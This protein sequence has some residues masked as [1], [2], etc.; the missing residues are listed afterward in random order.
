MSTPPPR[1][2][3]YTRLHAGQPLFDA[4]QSLATCEWLARLAQRACTQRPRRQV[5]SLYVVLTLA[6]GQT[7]A[8]TL[9]L[10]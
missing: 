8:M 6:D 9:P 10:N 2:D 1:F 7:H 5:R 4:G 3:P